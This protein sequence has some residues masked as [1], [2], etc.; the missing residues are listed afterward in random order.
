VDSKK[1]GISNCT[2]IGRKM[3]DI[4]YAAIAIHMGKQLSRSSFYQLIL[5]E[6]TKLALSPGEPGKLGC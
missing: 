2:N 5:P 1:M 4:L 6:A 3:A